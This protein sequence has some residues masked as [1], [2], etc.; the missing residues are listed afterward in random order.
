MSA[1]FLCAVCSDPI[2]D[3]STFRTLVAAEIDKM[4]EN[5]H[6]DG[7]VRILADTW[8]ELDTAECHEVRD[9]LI[10]RAVAC[11]KY[12]KGHTYDF[13]RV[14]VKGA[15]FLISGGM[16]YGNAPAEA[17]D[18]IWFLANSGWDRL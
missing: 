15:D 18:A 5:G 2:D 6:L 4:A 13:A 16:S 12:L 11:H 10:E 9:M 8:S 3:A 1:D 17:C 14:R 7:F